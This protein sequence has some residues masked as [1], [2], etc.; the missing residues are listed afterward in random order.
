MWVKATRI[1][2]TLMV[3]RRLCCFAVRYKSGVSCLNSNRWTLTKAQ[4]KRLD[5]FNTKTLRSIVGVR[6][7]DYVTNASILIRTGQP[8]L[9]TTIR[10]LR[11]SAFGHISIHVNPPSFVRRL[12]HFG[13]AENL[14]PGDEHL[15][16]FTVTSS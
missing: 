1:V 15:R 12:R 13:I 2:V 3:C 8:L 11:L 14:R 5:A 6:W 10:K 7:H 9:T 16:H 4:K